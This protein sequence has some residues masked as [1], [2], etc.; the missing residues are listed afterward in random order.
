ML[1]RDH[2]NMSHMRYA[3]KKETML[4]S[5]R[6]L[7][8]KTIRLLNDKPFIGLKNDQNLWTIRNPCD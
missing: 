2:S 1:R 6:L 5:D 3:H 8:R 4:L 7:A